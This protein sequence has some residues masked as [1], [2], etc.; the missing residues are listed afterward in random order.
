MAAVNSET[1]IMIPNV[2][3]DSSNGSQLGGHEVNFP[4]FH[5]GNNY[6]DRCP[7]SPLTPLACASG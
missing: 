3:I 1:E 4:S 2:F 5:H 6:M 7:Q